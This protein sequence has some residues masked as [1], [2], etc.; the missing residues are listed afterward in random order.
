ME[1]RAIARGIHT[2]AEDR[3]YN[4]GPPLPPWGL[5]AYEPALLRP[6]SA[7]AELFQAPCPNVLHAATPQTAMSRVHGNSGERQHHRDAFCRCH[8]L[9]AKTM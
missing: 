6:G 9:C 7:E 8:R 1:L 3:W 5:L 4:T 2:A